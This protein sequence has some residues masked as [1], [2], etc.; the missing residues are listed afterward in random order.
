VLGMC[1]ILCTSFF[2]LGNMSHFFFI[3]CVASISVSIVGRFFRHMVFA[4]GF[5]FSV[6]ELGLLT[7][8]GHLV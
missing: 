4:D 8:Q 2:A 7:N 3:F 5:L 1:Y 6:K